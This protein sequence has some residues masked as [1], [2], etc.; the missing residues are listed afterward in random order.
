[1]Y[2]VFIEWPLFEATTSTH[3][4]FTLFR[5]LLSVLLLAFLEKKKVHVGYYI[6]Y[7]LFLGGISFS[8]QPNMF[9]QI[10]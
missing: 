3:C 6:L 4:V 1:M 5:L 7:V 9:P 8:G 10:N 2:M